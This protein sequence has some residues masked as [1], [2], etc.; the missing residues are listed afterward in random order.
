MY[1][2][3][4]PI[5]SNKELNKP[6]S[7]AKRKPRL[8]TPKKSK[9]LSC[10]DTFL[11]K[12]TDRISSD[13]DKDS[14]CIEHIKSRNKAEIEETE[15][16]EEINKENIQCLVCKWKFPE[17]MT[18]DERNS[19]VNLCLDNKGEKHKAAYLSR[20]K[21]AEISELLLDSKTAKE[22][23]LCGKIFRKIG[24][25]SKIDHIRD[26]LGFDTIPL[27]TKTKKRGIKQQELKG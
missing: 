10:L 26:C 7:T 4:E 3:H 16:D 25:D 17:M 9:S 5:L 21:L 13:M 6:K 1:V 20:L 11:K 2:S 8:I 22:C 27:I 24:F 15:V 12:K 19:H 23:P 14:T 18:L